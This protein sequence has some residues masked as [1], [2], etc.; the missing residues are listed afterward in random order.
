MDTSKVPRFLLAHSVR[1][2]FIVHFG[3]ADD[4]ISRF[5]LHHFILCDIRLFANC[6]FGTFCNVVLVW[7]TLTEA[8]SCDVIIYQRILPAN[9]PA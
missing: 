7:L 5:P 2:L 9:L 8:F 3:D 4:Y 6:Y 1:T